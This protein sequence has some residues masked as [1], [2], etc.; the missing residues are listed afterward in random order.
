MRRKE[1]WDDCRAVH[2]TT[3]S[4]GIRD[5]IGFSGNPNA[6]D[7]MSEQTSQDAMR[8]AFLKRLH[9]AVDRL[10][11]ISSRRTMEAV[12]SIPD[13]IDAMIVALQHASVSEGIDP[14]V[15]ARIRGIVSREQLIEEAGG[16]LQPKEAAARL[17]VTPRSLT[18][19]RSRGEILAVSAGPD[20]W[21][22]PA[23]QFDE[24]GLVPGMQEL[25]NALED[26]VDPWTRLA[27]LVA[28]S[29]ARLGDSSALDLLRE[30]RLED[31]LELAG[32]YGEQ[33]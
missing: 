15:G 18:G 7:G 10:A 27:V 19:R 2:P 9:G 1:G 5:Y 30:G 21:E 13:P 14:L 32:T 29:P 22:Y 24:D 28:R 12:L 33:G 6:V 25:L 17:G 16:L 3:T 11:E 20:T 31:A 8:T 26:E 4:P 23:C